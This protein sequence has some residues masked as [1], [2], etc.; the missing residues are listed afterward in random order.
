MKFYADLHVHSKYSRATSKNCDLE[1]LSYWAR[2]K[3]ITVIGTG[4]F[5]HPAWFAELQEKLIPA[6]PGLFRL[7]P[8]IESQVFQKLASSCHDIT[9]FMLCVEVSTIYRKGD[10]T[11]KI[12]HLIYV[13]TF[14]QAAKINH[15]LEKIGN[16][17]SDGRP[18]LG[19][20]SRDL[21]EIVLSAGEDCY[22][23]PAHI[24]T[25]WFAVLG[26]K[27]GFDSIAECYRDL[28]DHVF[29]V[30]TGLSSDPEM[31]WRI[32]SLDRYRLMSN[33]DAHSPAKLGREA[34][35]FDTDLSYFSIKQALQTG[36]GFQGTVEFFPEEGKYHLDGH[37]KCKVRLTPEE[38]QRYH[39][40]CP[41][42]Q[43]PLTLGVMYRVNEL[44]DR[45]Q[46]LHQTPNHADF[47]S[48]IP[49]PE[50]M[51][52]V[53]S[54]G[55]A[56]KRV[57]QNYENIIQKLG[58][59]LSILTQQPIEDIQRV[60]SSLLGEA[61]ARMRRGQVIREAGFDGEYGRIKLF[62]QQ[63]LSQTSSNLKQ[64]KDKDDQM[65]LF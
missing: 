9:R 61:V 45:K 49:L 35:A 17:C 25:P 53:L 27:S 23:V 5:T 13:P 51:S 65:N 18:I 52:E 50:V 40:L 64:K 1:N 10:K 19:L 54:V 28:A 46:I 4:D 62:S 41:H 39:G 8:E 24:W 6:E 57:Q 12:H 29:A 20:D 22:L 3:G 33:S 32:S 7:K 38:S 30:E 11:R 36:Q 43:K 60:S 42:C 56:S 34:N 2:K 26:S 31:N 15:R 55:P 16:I 48:L 21:L 59:E 44:S 37:R 63:E 14:E 47:Q 58:S